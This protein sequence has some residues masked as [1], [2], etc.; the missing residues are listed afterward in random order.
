MNERYSKQI[1]VTEIG[2]SGQEKLSHA[3]ILIAGAGGL[4][5]PVA[6]YLAACG[7]G[8]IGIVDGDKVVRSNLNRQ[9]A[10]SADDIGL[11]KSKQLANRLSVQNP[12]I[13]IASFEFFLNQENAAEIIGGYDVVC[14]C[15]DNTIARMLIDN[16]CLLMSK[17]LIYAGVKEWEGYITVLHYRKG[18][19]LSDLFSSESLK[20]IACNNASQNGIINT[21]CGIA[22]SIQ[23]TEAIKVILGF[24]SALDGYV[25]CFNALNQVYKRFIIQK[26]Q[27]ASD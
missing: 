4:G 15:T 25:L 21:T 1:T 14:D 10:Y 24:E 6:S 8:N 5:T 27:G 13:A 2:E 18:I 16:T 17:P 20:E 22:G 11:S 7:V 3:K 26:N 12:E 19:A 23:A 9:F